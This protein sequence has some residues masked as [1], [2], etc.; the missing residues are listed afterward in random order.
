MLY[1]NNIL[2]TQFQQHQQKTN[3]NVNMN[4]EDQQKIF[5]HLKSTNKS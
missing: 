4:L 2:I 1:N 3:K 5:I